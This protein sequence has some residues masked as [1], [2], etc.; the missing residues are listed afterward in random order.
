VA[1]E[2]LHTHAADGALIRRYLALAIFVAIP[3]LSID[4]I[5]IRWGLFQRAEVHRLLS[6]ATD[7]GWGD[8]PKF[9][10]DVRA[11]TQPGDSIAVIVPTMGWDAGYSYAF[12]RASY[13]LSGREVL[14]IVTEDGV[15]HPQNF[16]RAKYIAT[17]RRNVRDAT[18]HVVWTGDNGALLE[19]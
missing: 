2:R 12:Y 1:R 18:R 6:N 13:F 7:R 16:A 10:E 3:L 15:V 14:P 11:H 9:L 8:Y 4:P 19:H 5:L 17:W